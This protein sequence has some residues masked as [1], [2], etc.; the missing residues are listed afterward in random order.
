V[1]PF[2]ASA[3]PNGSPKIALLDGHQRKTVELKKRKTSPNTLVDI[4]IPD[5][6]LTEREKQ[7]AV[8]RLR[9]NTGH[10]EKDR[11]RGFFEQADLLEWGFPEEKLLEFGFDLEFP[12]EPAAE[13]K[14]AEPRIEE[15]KKL[16]RKWKVGLGDVFALGD[17]RLI[18]G[19]STDPETV[20]RLMEGERAVLIHSDPPYGMGKEAEGIANDNLYKEKLDRFQMEWWRA[21]RPHIEDNSSAYIWGHAADLWR[22]WYSGGLKESERITLR[23][24]IVWDKQDG[25]NPTLRV[26]GKTFENNR[27]F[28]RSERA[29]FVMLGE[30]GFNNNSDNY[31]EGWEPI[32][33]YLAEQV[34][35]MGWGPK[36]IE[37]ITGVGMF[38]HWFTKSQFTFITEEHYKKLK[39][40]AGESA[41]DKD[42]PAFERDY[43]I[44]SKEYETLRNEFYSTRAFFDSTFE[45]MTDVWN[46][47]R[48]EGEERFGH[49]T[50]KPVS[51]ISRIV[52]CSSP[53]G[54]VILA[55][56][57][58]TSPEIIAAQN[59]GRK[60]RA[61]DISP[62]YVALSLQRFEDAFGIKPERVNT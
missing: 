2:V 8:I 32:R 16:V 38:G 29:L 27:S 10:L 43:K 40:A 33:A 44:F 19:D 7:E 46:F 11:L 52:R 18:C 23:N 3:P 47:P 12:E 31:W 20:S 1:I 36:D 17:H 39:E 24:E 53:A 9:M 60:A 57:S 49:S 22:L 15:A 41:F 30:Q 26:N 50:P 37:K 28:Y 25:T 54:S 42:Y 4:R 14:D 59:L 13:E 48:V 55:P 56:F 58:G 51:M 21:C 5:R 35:R 62:E 34:E 61:I 45:N 6:P